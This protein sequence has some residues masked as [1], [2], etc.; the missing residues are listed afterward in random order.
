[1][2]MVFAKAPQAQFRYQI[3]GIFFAIF[4]MRFSLLLIGIVPSL[5]ELRLNFTGALSRRPP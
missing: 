3:A 4:Q 5:N 2:L 1:M